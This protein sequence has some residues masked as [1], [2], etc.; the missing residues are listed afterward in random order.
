MTDAQPG[1]FTAAS[2]NAARRV[3]QALLAVRAPRARAR[4][5]HRAPHLLPGEGTRPLLVP[6]VS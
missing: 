4:S 3:E 1:P 6:F 2:T 5:S